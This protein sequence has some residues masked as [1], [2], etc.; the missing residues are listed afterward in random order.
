[1]TMRIAFVWIVFWATVSVPLFA[2]NTQA[3]FDDALNLSTSGN[4]VAAY[5]SLKAILDD[6]YLSGNL[7]YNLGVIST[8]LDS[9][10]VAKLYF[11]AASRYTD[12]RQ[13]ALE[14]IAFLDSRFPQRVAELPRL[15]WEQFFDWL[16][17][18]IGITSLFWS[19][20]VIAH[21][22]VLLYMLGWHVGRPRWLRG[23]YLS[24]ALYVITFLSVLLYIDGRNQRF[25]DGVIIVGQF[26]LK[27]LPDTTS[28]VISQAYE[29]FSFI[30][31]KQVSLQ[32]P[33][34]L[35]VR[36]SNGLYGWLPE[37]ALRTI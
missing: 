13:I 32:H 35:Y 26:A 4:N 15:P 20:V 1:M 11:I 16:E 17:R 30:V 29:G 12:T 34:W 22:G 6:G 37:S 23:A 27:E 9:L 21:V 2:Q 7:Y 10:S 31:D 28:A 25:E 19:I 14:G 8:K 3:R 18:A 36:M 5:D 24:A 33:G